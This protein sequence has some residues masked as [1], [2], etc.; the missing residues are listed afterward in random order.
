MRARR[1]T[2]RVV[3]ATAVGAGVLLGAAC[4]SSVGHAARESASRSEATTASVGRTPTSNAAKAAG[5]DELT[6]GRE[7]VI[8]TFCSGSATV[9]VTIGPTAKTFTGGTCDDSTGELAVNVGV[10]VGPDFPP[11]RAKPDYVGALIDVKSSH[12]SA[13]TARIDG[14]GGVVTDVRTT[15][16]ADRRSVRL[17]GPLPGTKD[18][19]TVDVYC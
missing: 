3:T 8:R 13:F 7:G 9:S 1:N 19:A 10:V 6:A 17:R 2:P 4:T 5:C 16:S 11:G 14:M 12:S 15:V 18:V